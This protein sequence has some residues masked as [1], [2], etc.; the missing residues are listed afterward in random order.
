MED[1]VKDKTTELLKRQI[2]RHKKVIETNKEL[3]KLIKIQEEFKK[4]KREYEEKQREY[5]TTI[6]PFNEKTEDERDL[7][8]SEE[9]NF[10]IKNSESH[11]KD[12]EKEL[13]SEINEVNEVKP[14]S[15]TYHD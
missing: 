4:T 3:L 7:A 10:I 12:L 6:R 2:E 14:E 11:I 13:I 8:T 5:N 9:A 15:K 1:E